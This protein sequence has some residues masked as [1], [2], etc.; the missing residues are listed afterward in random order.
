MRLLKMKKMLKMKKTTQHHTQMRTS[1]K[2]K[3]KRKRMVMILDCINH[4]ITIHC[5]VDSFSFVT[6]WIHT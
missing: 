4:T 2:T 3:W 5:E 6:T 1:M